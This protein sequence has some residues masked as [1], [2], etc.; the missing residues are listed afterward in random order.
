VIQ[1]DPNHPGACHL[2][3]H[4]IEAHEPQRGVPCAERLA[5]LMP[6]AGHIVHMPGHIY[7][8]I[9]RY[10]DAVDVNRHA[11]H[12]DRTFLEGPAA[13]RGIYGSSY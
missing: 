10:K 1:R 6:G 12:A 5:A 3:I 2:F 4:T 7:I 8:R 11:V 13:K 9:G